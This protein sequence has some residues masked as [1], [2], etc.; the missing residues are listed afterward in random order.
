[1]R[2][3]TIAKFILCF[4]RLCV[5]LTCSSCLQRSVEVLWIGTSC[6]CFFLFLVR[7]AAVF[8]RW[9]NQQTMC[10]KCRGGLPKTHPVTSLPSNSRAGTLNWKHESISK[11][12]LWMSLTALLESWWILCCSTTYNPAHYNLKADRWW[13]KVWQFY[14]LLVVFNCRATGANDV[15][16][17]VL[18]CGI[19]HSDYH[20]IHNDWKSSM[21]PMVPG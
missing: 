19:C 10:M 14:E 7:L 13:V 12:V 20:Q 11:H 3:V 21:Y 8:W 5:Q 6:T 15:R 2:V 16:M 17:K 4:E 9:E 1:M 18:Y